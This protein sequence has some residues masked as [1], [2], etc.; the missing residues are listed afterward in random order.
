MSVAA[1]SQ[2]HLCGRNFNEIAQRLA[3][4]IDDGVVSEQVLA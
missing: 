1:A 3:N 4:H 2:E